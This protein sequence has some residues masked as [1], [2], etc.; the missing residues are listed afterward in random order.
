MAAALAGYGSECVLLWHDNS[1]Q[2]M[3]ITKESATGI[4]PFLKWA[5]GKTQLLPAIEA[6]VLKLLR[7]KDTI[8]FVEPFVGSGAVLFFMLRKYGRHIR[9]A[10]INDV[11]PV[12]AN[13][14]STIK[15]NPQELINVLEALEKQYFTYTSE[16]DRKAFF[17]EK[18]IEFNALDGEVV[19]K[20]ALL[21]FLNK[22]C[23]NGL[24]R[25]NSKGHFNVPFGKYVNPTICNAPVILA[26]SEA[27]QK[28]EILNTDF[29]E[30]ERLIA[31]DTFFYLDPPYKPISATSSFNAYAKEGFGDADQERLK[32][33]C[34][35]VNTGGGYFVQSNSDNS[36]T[37]EGNGFFQDL[38]KGYN[39]EQVKAKRAINAKG[40]G[41][42]AVFELL[43]SNDAVL[44]DEN[45]PQV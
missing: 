42:G 38:Y 34:D 12:L 41:R 39:I 23:F 22:T 15:Y 27:L 1:S 33:F 28:V 10:T 30:M 18:R 6:R 5:G 14:Y 36:H 9:Q 35:K 45:V 25:V 7:V 19:Q 40:S 2:R 29:S 31:P 26:N 32:A 8:Q 37:D 21:L 4:K 24:Y 20:S 3:T 13:C 17:L 11:N 16:D 44:Q 43:I